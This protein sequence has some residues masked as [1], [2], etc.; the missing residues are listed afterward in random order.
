[1]P[2][3]LLR[4]G[5]GLLR[6]R[7]DPRLGTGARGRAATR[8]VAPGE[9]D[10]CCSRSAD[11]SQQR[12]HRD[13]HQDRAPRSGDRD[14]ARPG[15]VRRVEPRVRA[16]G[17]GIRGHRGPQARVQLVE[18]TG[19]QLE[20]D[21]ALGR[22]H[23]AEADV[24]VSLADAAGGVR[25]ADPLGERR[26]VTVR[27]RALEVVH[28]SRVG[29][30]RWFGDDDS[31]DTVLAMGDLLITVAP[32]GAETTKDDCPQLPTTLAELVETARA[33]RSRRGRDDPRAHPRCRAST[34]ARPDAAVGHGG[35]P[36]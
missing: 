32:T 21:H 19:H 5:L 36:A 17:R 4:D 13:Q 10:E 35:S 30:S 16:P 25:L 27:G 2:D 15:R 9:R 29:G 3:L 31:R 7:R 20:L 1:M 22:A 14:R 18:I 28:S 8:A 33:L 6:C 26:T 11:D 12:D 23:V 24:P 34:H